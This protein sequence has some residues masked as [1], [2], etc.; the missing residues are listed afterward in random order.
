MLRRGL[1]IVRIV[2]RPGRNG[3]FVGGSTLA[4][5]DVPSGDHHRQETSWATLIHLPSESPV[6]T[7]TGRADPF[8]LSIW[9][10]SPPGSL[11]LVPISTVSVNLTSEWRC[12]DF[13]RMACIDESD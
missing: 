2:E 12:R 6:R 9:F 3:V 10:P 8:C 1:P 7:T 4:A 5:V 11:P 13:P